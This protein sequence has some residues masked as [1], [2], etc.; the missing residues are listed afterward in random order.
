MPD[1][2]LQESRQEVAS[3]IEQTGRLVDELV[4]E[5]AQMIGVD[6][7]QLVTARQAIRQGFEGLGAS[8]P[9]EPH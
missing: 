9:K 3:I 5:V 2:K 1:S 4:D 6:A 7:E 8:L